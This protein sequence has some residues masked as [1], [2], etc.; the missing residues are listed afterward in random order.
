MRHVCLRVLG[1]LVITVLSLTG[2]HR[3]LAYDQIF[4]FG[5]SVSD[6]GNV[7]IGS[8]GLTPDPMA[9][10][11]GRFSNG[12]IW[13]DRLA[14]AYGESLTPSLA[15]TDLSTQSVNF[16]WGGSQTG[17][18]N[19]TPDG[20]SI[21]PG[22]NGQISG[23]PNNPFLPPSFSE[24]LSFA[25]TGANPDALYIV[26]S[27]SN[28]FIIPPPNGIPPEVSAA[29]IGNAITTLYDLGARH[30]LV[31]NLPDLGSTPLAQLA[32]LAEPLS[33]A[34]AA[35]NALLAAE[36]ESLEGSL[37]GID[38]VAPDMN[39]LI[40]TLLAYPEVFGFIDPASQP[41]FGAGPASG[42]L[43]TTIFPFCELSEPDPAP[44]AFWYDEQHPTTAVHTWAG[45]GAFIAVRC[46]REDFRRKRKYVK[47]VARATRKYFGVNLM[48]LDKESQLIGKA[49][50]TG[51]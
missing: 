9:Y 49:M 27:G 7:F 1:A 18:S 19:F 28:D 14:M 21:V 16:A 25:G 40:A 46:V 43:I 33:A 23:D 10:S 36:L 15:A 26:W 17:G 5:D 6:S 32:G 42:C 38:I 22:L 34:T 4:V 11:D 31:I 50:R 13:V 44:G 30:F 8:G 20:L 45:L 48:A 47:C 37:P 39:A 51:K 2:A 12:L 41:V 29:N 35:F 24:I 3:A